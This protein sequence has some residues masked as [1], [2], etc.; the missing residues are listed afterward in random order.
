MTT[1]STDHHPTLRHGDR[2]AIGNELQAILA[3]LVDLSLA[4]KHAHCP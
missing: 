2:E 1:L 3:I 4:G